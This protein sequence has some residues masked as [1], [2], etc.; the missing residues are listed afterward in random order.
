MRSGS[1]PAA[2]KML[3]T[4][5]FFCAGLITCSTALEW[6]SPSFHRQ[7]GIFEKD[8]DGSPRRDR[9]VPVAQSKRF[10]YL[11]CHHL[12]RPAIDK[13][14]TRAR[15]FQST[16]PLTPPHQVLVLNQHTPSLSP[17]RVVAF[18]DDYYLWWG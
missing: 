18:T 2:G 10:C 8:D 13:I 3:L 11:P 12:K 4:L 14:Y 6:I 16:E 17:H 1:S 9:P 15:P 7:I 5:Y